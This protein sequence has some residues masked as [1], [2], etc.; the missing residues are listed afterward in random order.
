MVPV[1]WLPGYSVSDMLNLGVVEIGPPDMPLRLKLV[2]L[3][4]IPP[5]CE[6]GAEE[7]PL[8]LAPCWVDGLGLEDMAIS[9]SLLETEL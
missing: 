8:S 1:R 2:V 6:V 7:L 4:L 9:F 5:N 3:R